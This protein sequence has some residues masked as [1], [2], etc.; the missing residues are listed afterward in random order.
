[1]TLKS[2]NY[3]LKPVCSIITL[4]LNCVNPVTKKGKEGLI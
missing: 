3:R 1:M 2:V 4:S